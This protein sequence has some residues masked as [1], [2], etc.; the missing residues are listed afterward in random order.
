MGWNL[1]D[2]NKTFK[3]CNWCYTTNIEAKEKISERYEEILTA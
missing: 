2:K 3:V 1:L